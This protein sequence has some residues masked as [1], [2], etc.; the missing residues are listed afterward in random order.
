MSNSD[1]WHFASERRQRR[2]HGGCLVGWA[3]HTP[4]NA[5]TSTTT[6]ETL[7]TT[8]N[9][10]VE[11]KRRVS[12]LLTYLKIHWIRGA[13]IHPLECHFVCQP[14]PNSEWVSQS[15]ALEGQRLGRRLTS[16]LVVCIP[17]PSEHIQI[18]ILR[19]SCWHL[20]TTTFAHKKCNIIWLRINVKLL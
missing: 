19:L 2:S 11:C 1:I 13:L 16:W 5:R 7:P 3:T 20:T 14:N 17:F 6:A 9:K 4:G 15:V 18:H 10:K 8:S 12:R